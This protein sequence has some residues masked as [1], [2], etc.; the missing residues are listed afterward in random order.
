MCIILMTLKKIVNYYTQKIIPNIT[1][2]IQTNKIK[3]VKTSI[4]IYSKVTSEINIYTIMTKSI[5][6]YMYITYNREIIN[7]LKYNLQ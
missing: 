1:Q 5:Y 7:Q 6:Y 3:D 4:Q 2:F